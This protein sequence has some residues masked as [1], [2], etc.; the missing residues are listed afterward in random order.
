M[1]ISHLKLLKNYLYLFSMYS[2][3]YLLVNGLNRLENAGPWNENKLIKLSLKKRIGDPNLGLKYI[4]PNHPIKF[5]KFSKCQF[6][7]YILVLC[8]MCF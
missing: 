4:Y 1:L 6:S 2:C 3:R 8:S 5:S 7:Y